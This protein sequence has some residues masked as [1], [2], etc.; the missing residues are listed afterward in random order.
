MKKMSKVKIILIICAISFLIYTLYQFITYFIQPNGLELIRK[1]SF[2]LSSNII[3][4]VAITYVAS[5]I[6]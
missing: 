1:N 5:L 3:A 4:G 2:E 6:D